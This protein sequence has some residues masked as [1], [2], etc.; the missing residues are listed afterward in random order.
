MDKKIALIDVRTPLE[1]NSGNVKGSIN[2]PMNE[3]PQRLDEIR[4]L[5]PMI[6][7][8]KSGVRSQKV[9]EFLKDNGIV[10]VENGGGWM[11]VNASVNE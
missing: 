10:E 5:E 11:E 7:F 1:F 2:I 6:V 9:L 4:E 8:C 3:V